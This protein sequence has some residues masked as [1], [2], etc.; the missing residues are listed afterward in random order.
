MKNLSVV[1][2]V[3]LYHSPGGP[4]IHDP[5]QVCVDLVNMNS[6]VLV[7]WNDSDFT[8]RFIK[9][10]QLFLALFKAY[11]IY[12]KDFFIISKK[13]FSIKLYI[14]LQEG[15][16]VNLQ[17]ISWI[18]YYKLMKG[19][20]TRN[21]PVIIWYCPEDLNQQ[22]SLSVLS[23]YNLFSGVW[24][25]NRIYHTSGKFGSGPP[26]TT[27]LSWIKLANSLINRGLYT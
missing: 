20:S 19:N 8:T 18:K 11:R 1:V 17:K 14:F 7:P 21:D 10:S 26:S 22:A 2:K 25:M 6:R 12:Y 24:W 16:T 27:S 13:Y 9:W 15:W 3:F 4:V 5:R 23:F